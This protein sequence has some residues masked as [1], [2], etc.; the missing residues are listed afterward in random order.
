MPDRI[1]TPA[2]RHPVDPVAF[3]VALIGAPLLV[4]ALGFWMLLIP[5]AAVLYGGIPYLLIGGPMLFLSLQRYEATTTTFEKIGYYAM[6]LTL[7]AFPVFGLVFG[8]TWIDIGSFNLYLVPF[9][10]LFAP[11]WC[12][13]FGNLYIRFRREPHVTP[14]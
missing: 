8:M 3:I 1:S 7:V 10:Y 4:A 12:Q 2:L 11:I 14:F 9:G 13:V 5:V 6:T